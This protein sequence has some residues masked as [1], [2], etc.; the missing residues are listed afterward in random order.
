MRKT[1]FLLIIVTMVVPLDL[2]YASGSSGVDPHGG[3][4]PC[5][6]CPCP[7]GTSG[8]G[9]GGG[10]GPG[11]GSPGGFGGGFPPEG[12]YFATPSASAAPVYLRYGTIMEQ[13][14]DLHL[15]SITEPWVMDRTYSSGI[16]G[17]TTVGNK[18]MGGP[19]DRYLVQDGSNISYVINADSSLLFTGSGSPVSFTSPDSSTF[20][21]THD[22]IAD[23]Y[24][25]SDTEGNMRLIFNDFTVSPTVERG[26]LKEETTDQWNSQ[27]KT[28]YEYSYNTNGTLS[29]ITT[30]EGQDYSIVFTYSGTTITKVEIKDVSNNLIRKVEYTYYGNVTSPST[31]IGSSGDLVQ[32]KVSWRATADSAGTLSISRYTQYR[33][34][35]NSQLK[36]VYEHDAI[37][38]I[39]ESDVGISTPEDIMSKADTYGT[40]DIK[41][42]ASRSFEFYA[43]STSTSNIATPFDGSGENLNTLYGGADTNE[44]GYV[45]SETIGA[46]CSQCGGIG[47]GVKKTYFYL[48]LAQGATID[49]NEVVRIVIED[50]EDADGVAQYRR[51][52]GFNDT[53]RMLREVF[54]EDPTGTPSYWCKSSVMDSS[55]KEHRVSE[56]RMPSAHAVTTAANL[57]TFLDPYDSEGNSWSNDTNTL[58][59]SEGLIN[60][61]TYSSEGMRTDHK[62]K[63]GS[64]GTAYYVWAADYGDGDGDSTGA[65]YD[66]KTLITAEY[67]YQTQTTSRASGNKTSYSYTFWDSNDREIKKITTTL[68]VIPSSQNGSG[69]A[70]STEQYFDNLGRLRWRKDGEGFID[71]YSYNPSIG[72]KAYVAQD[73]DPVSPGT[74]VTSGSAG[75]WDAWTVGSANSNKPSRD[76]GLPT[77]INLTK[78][79]YFDVLG[80]SYK[81]I[82]EDGSEHYVVYEEDRTIQFPFWDSANSKTNLPITV[83]VLNEDDRLEELFSVRASFNNISTSNSEPVGFSTNPAQSDYVSWQVNTHDEVTG[84]LIYND[85]YHDIPS[86]GS[87][88]LSTNFYRTISQKDALGRQKYK[89]QVVSGSSASDRKEQ[90][91][92]Y[93][94]DVHSRLIETK[95]G[96]SGDSSSNSH[97]MTDDYDT[98]PTLRTISMTEYDNGGVGDGLVTKTKQF[99][100]TGTNDYTGT[101][102]QRTY[103]GHTRGLESFYMSGSTE[104]PFGPYWVRDVNWYGKP[105]AKALYDTVPTWSTVLTGDG[106]TTY[107]STTSTNRRTLEEVDH[108]NLGLV[109]ETREY[110][111]AESTGTGSDAIVFQMFYDRN[112]RLVADSQDYGAGTEFAYDGVGRQF[113]SREVIR[114]EETSYSTGAYNYRA[115]VPHPIIS[116]MSGGDD[117][118]ITLNH[119]VYEGSNAIGW[120]HFEDNHD[121][122]VSAE[123]G[124]DLTNNDDY[125][126]RSNYAWFNASRRT[127]A[128]ADYGSGDTTTGAGT[129]KYSSIPSRP[130]SAPSSSDTKLVTLFGHNTDTGQ[131]E[132]VTT[133]EGMVTKAFYDDLGRTKYIAEN[134]DN[135]NAST[136]ANTG[137]S[138]DKSK[139]RCTKYTYNGLNQRVTETAM[140]KNADGNL[141]DN[142]ITS[143]LFE[144]TISGRR[145]TNEIYPDSSDTTSSGSDQVKY[146]FNVDGS[147]SQRTDQRG[148]VLDYTYNNGRQ[149]DLTKVT[150]LGGGTDS[151][152][153]SIKRSYND[154]GLLEKLSSYANSDGTGTVRNEVQYEYNDL[155]Q[156]TTSYQSHEGAVNTGTTP[157]VQYSYD[158]TVN[159]STFSRF[160]RL[161]SVT[162]PNGRTVFYDYDSSNSE[163]PANR[164][165]R[166]D[167][168]RETDSSGTILAEYDYSGLEHLVVADL[169]EPDIKLDYFQGTSGTYAGLDRF[170]RIK[171]QYW[172]GYGSTSDVD[173]FKYAHDYAGNHKYHDIDSAIYSTNNKDQ[174]YTYDGLNRLVTSDHGT[175]SGSTITGTPTSQ[176]EW[177]LGAVDNWS[178]YTTKTSGTTDLDQDRTSGSSNEITDITESTGPSWATPA[179]DAAGNMT[180]IPKPSN[181]TANYTATYDAWN[182]IVKLEESGTTVVEYEYDGLNQR[183]VKTD[184]T[185]MSDVVYD[186][187]FNENWQSLEVRK[188]GDTDPYEQ[189][190][191]HPYYIDAVLLRDYDADVDGSS[192]RH[193]FMHDAKFNVS[194]I[195]DSSGAVTERYQYTPFGNQSVLDSDFSADADGKSDV[196][197]SVGFT[198]RSIDA[199]SGLQ[200]F[201]TRYY[202]A[203]VGQFVSRDLLGYVDGQNMYA[204]Y[205]APRG[206]DPIGTST[207]FHHWFPQS[208]GIQ[209]LI[210]ELCEGF[211]VHDYT[212]PVEGFRRGSQHWW[213]HHGQGFNYNNRVVELIDDADGDCCSFMSDMVELINNTWANLPRQGNRIPDLTTTRYPG[214]PRQG[215][216][217]VFQDLLDDMDDRCNDPTRRP[218]CPDPN[219]STEL[220]WWVPANPANDIWQDVGIGVGVAVL[221]VGGAVAAGAAGGAAAGGTGAASVGGA[222][223]IVPSS[224]SAAGTAGAAACRCFQL[225]I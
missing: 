106:Y 3:P 124:I 163:Y 170:G 35:S 38:R 56:D 23:E 129:W 115:P 157:K 96:V 118:V 102:Y 13:S 12:L 165:S 67:S 186:Y 32:V 181:L 83:R 47:G 119:T 58:N 63:K 178:N 84:E 164:L 132:T 131:R 188:D 134:F 33:Y 201:R 213:I 10:G 151:H 205:F 98:Y 62:V 28:G 60:V 75:N 184:K 41:D 135:F 143:Y 104:T 91:T 183:I 159:G 44:T 52:Y 140:D 122:Q 152:I 51:V 50:T 147:L 174:A 197:N 87:G 136:E 221:V 107:A 1:L 200:Y 158:T 27:S 8:P 105:T 203:S 36:A 95:K 179:Y 17:A 154:M 130:S 16:S 204:A 77:A 45:K 215:P 26:R 224:S 57:R 176:E 182:R 61:Y 48:D 82:D 11:G 6:T 111:I 216:S 72:E 64:S 185:G 97:N 114:V 217:N 142:Q 161:E 109:Y 123:R 71:Y 202:H 145:V 18:W 69:I 90:V 19:A 100:G 68:P 65:D 222:A 37:Q 34:N 211:D 150:T 78:K 207:Q 199:I 153:R 108:N 194:A 156:T 120:H 162:Y 225:A 2:A 196:A 103:R 66:D 101:N 146:Q 110:K 180:S 149:P 22:A 93:V 74:D 177:T 193:Y 70:I 191:Y 39:I 24:T 88:T 173:R 190:V 43:S 160:H 85:R 219:P 25:L 76:A 4:C 139:D 29:Q 223:T 94:Y 172:K 166:I 116:S 21:L 53:G 137:D 208:Q 171:E 133:P 117:Y 99:F 192:N 209:S 31:N 127:T 169:P 220:P 86:S 7:P 113:Q 30:P 126:R 195:T 79:T 187:Y 9:P 20:K 141:N 5:T 46:G 59:T 125:I 168:I 167:K 198:G 40:P 14:I 206:V 92:Q 155:G 218:R 54:I 89:I 73:V 128:T 138:T 15:P 144:D 210:G 175:L 80:N 189:F 214:R 112:G 49:Q 148:T 81:F 42:F 121:D 212:T 55:G